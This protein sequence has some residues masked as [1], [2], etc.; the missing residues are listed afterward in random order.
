MYVCNVYVT[1]LYRDRERDREWAREK[2]PIT[3]YENTIHM[4]TSMIFFVFVHSLLINSNKT[5]KLYQFYVHD[6]YPRL[7]KKIKQK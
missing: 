7:Y 5:Y 1:L 3:F 4:Q 6:M 2:K